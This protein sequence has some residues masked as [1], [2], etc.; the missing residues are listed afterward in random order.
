MST[1]PTTFAFA[2]LLATLVGCDGSTPVVQPSVPE[3]EA[4]SA[5][6]DEPRLSKQTIT[7]QD[8]A[9]ERPPPTEE[10]RQAALRT[11]FD[12]AIQRV[13]AEHAGDAQALARAEAEVDARSAETA[14]MADVSLHATVPRLRTCSRPTGPGDHRDGPIELA[15]LLDADGLLDAWLIVD[16]GTEVREPFLTCAARVVWEADWPSSDSLRRFSISLPTDA[17]AP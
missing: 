12:R 17:E 16:E 3:D 8:P 2:S 11:N 13:I 15:V 6:T 14:T 4:S 5:G 1:S 9:G 10:Q 7:L